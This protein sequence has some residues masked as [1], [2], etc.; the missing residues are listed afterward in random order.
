MLSVEQA[1][2]S[3][4]PRFFERNPAV[5]T[6]PLVKFLRLLFHER[7]IN[8]FLE[9]NGNLGAF[10]LIEKVLEYFQFGYSVSNIDKE[11]IPATGKVVIVANHP[12]G[13]LDALALIRLVREVRKDVKVVAND[14]LMHLPPLRPLLLPVDNFSRSTS[15]QGIQ[16]IID[17]LE[18]E[19][20]VIIF[21][22]GEVSRVRPTGIK[23]ARWHNGF[24]RFAKKTQAPILPVFIDARNSAL[25]YGLSML[26]KPLA[27]LLLVHEM[28]GQRAKMVRFKV[29]E[30]VPFRNLDIH[31]VNGKTQVKLVKR[32]LYQISRNKKGVFATEKCVA[33]PED[34]QLLKRELKGAELLG[35]TADQ[36]KIYLCRPD[37]GSA[38]L[39][40][41]GRL[42]EVTFRAVAKAPA[43]AA[44]WTPTTPITSTWCCG[45]T[46]SWRWWAPT[47]WARATPSWPSTAP[48]ASTPAPCSNSRKASCPIWRTP[49]SWAAASCSRATG[50]RAPSTICGTASAPICAPAR[51]SAIY[52][53]P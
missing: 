5:V 7:E 30:P 23:D 52:S 18:N 19:E 39:R 16:R 12:L 22:S 10:E 8:H 43:S 17:S 20:A 40:E 31:G 6:G 33:H 9:S 15:K 1:L 34:R 38:L 51:T 47:A 26:Y 3:K 27:A 53:G 14:L 25:F 48:A 46:K 36:K 24:L 42:R 13:A 35:V 37:S 4:F 44:T 50:A 11:N 49:S 28:F 32:H 2:T 29:G 41:I 21:P 45:T